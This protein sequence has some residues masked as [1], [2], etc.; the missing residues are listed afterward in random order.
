[1]SAAQTMEDVSMFVSTLMVLMNASVD[2]ATDCPVIAGA[3]MVCHDY[4]SV[5]LHDT[6]Y[7]HRRVMFKDVGTSTGNALVWLIISRS[8]HAY[9]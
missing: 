8:V 9:N 1:M 4:I 2:V 7:S 3:V 6:L 5:A